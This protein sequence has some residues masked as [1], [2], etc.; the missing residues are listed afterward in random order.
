MIH[1]KSSKANTA[2]CVSEASKPVN[3]E[4]TSKSRMT[5][6]QRLSVIVAAIIS[7]TTPFMS[8]ALNL[9]VTSISSDFS[10]P[11]TTAT[12]VLNIYTLVFASL[13]AIMGHMADQRGK[14]RLILAGTVLFAIAGLFCAFAPNVYVLIAARGA[15]A[16]GTSALYTTSVTFMLMHFD[17][18]VKGRL[19]GIT[20]AAVYV[21]LSLGPVL[22]GFLNDTIGWRGIFIIISIVCVLVIVLTLQLD[23]D[24]VEKQPDASDRVGS[25]IFVVAMVLGMFGLT[26]L[27]QLPWSWACLVLGICMLVIFAAYEWRNE[28]PVI[29]VHLFKT[30]P[31]YTLSNL[32]ALLNYGA[33]AAI[34]YIV[35]LYLQNV[36]GFD[37]WLAGLVMVVVPACQ[38][39]IAPISGRMSDR[40][41][42]TRVSAAGLLVT[43]ISIIVLA[44]IKV[45]SSL[46]LIICG[47]VLEGIGMGFFAA[48]NNNAIL[49]CVDRSHY[50]E[51]NSMLATMRGTGQS[52][53]MAIAILMLNF[54]AGSQTVAQIAPDVLTGAIS[55]ILL[56]CSVLSVVALLLSLVRCGSK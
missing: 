4:K 5:K 31:T 25:T 17:P 8:S 27:N 55:N 24:T 50:S 45:D 33:T 18:G 26:E 11:A 56:V 47:L 23:D 14:R 1:M 42:A 30:S 35:A 29:N 48:P 49:S 34:S 54:A 51:A 21:G 53:S 3:C 28:H 7:V 20:S 52:T 2:A 12:W 41:P 9:S 19:L 32:S 38:V 36:M 39:V 6:K 10:C 44:Q 43:A 16:V 13:S 40:F 15:M 22:G 46:M 37:S